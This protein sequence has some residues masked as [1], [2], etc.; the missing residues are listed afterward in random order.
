M[1]TKSLLFWTPEQ[2]LKG[3]PNIPLIFNTRKIQ[4]SKS[5]L[6]LPKSSMDL[7]DFSYVFENKIYTFDDYFT[8]LNT[9]GLIV[10]KNG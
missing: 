6:K 5:V 8:Q 4:Q 2:Q 9:A 10:V 3:Y 7:E 1:A